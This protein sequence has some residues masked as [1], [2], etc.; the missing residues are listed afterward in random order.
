VNTEYWKELIDL[1]AATH[2]TLTLRKESGIEARW[3]IKVDN[4]D[5]SAACRRI[6]LD[7]AVRDVI[8][9]AS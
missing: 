1:L 2:S 6:E 4:P 7:D 9:L 8:G 5:W 3:S